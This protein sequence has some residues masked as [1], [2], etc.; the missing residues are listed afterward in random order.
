MSLTLH[1]LFLSNLHQLS[2]PDLTFA[3]GEGRAVLAKK[4]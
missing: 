3:D 1:H 2:Y 4:C